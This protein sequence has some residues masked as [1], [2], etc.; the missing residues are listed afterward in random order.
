MAKNAKKNLIFGH[1]M[2]IE[3]LFSAY[4]L[5]FTDQCTQYH[6]ALCTQV[7]C[8]ALL[9]TSLERQVRTEQAIGIRQAE[10][11]SDSSWKRG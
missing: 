2:P 1:Q 8:L 7:H 3:T 4:A 10:Y 5:K 11:L 9:E 6:R